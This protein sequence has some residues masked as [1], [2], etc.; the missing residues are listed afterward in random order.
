MLSL[1]LSLAASRRWILFG[2]D[3]TAAF[4]QGEEI[5]RTLVLSLPKDG[6]DG[7]E[8]G[9]LLL[10]RKP[11]YG[12]RDAPRG[13]WKR[14]HNAVLQHGLRP[15]PNEPAAYV[16]RSPQGQVQG[17]VVCHVDDLLW[18][19]S[20]EMQDVMG[21]LQQELRFGALEQG[22]FSYC[23]RVLT[24]TP[25]GIRVT[26]PNTAAKVRPVHLAQQR[27][28]QKDHPATDQEIN[29]LR[30]VLGSLNWV[31]RVCRPDISYELSVLQSVQKKA[32]VQDLLD[33]N[34]LLR[35]V[36]E[37]P[38]VGLFFPYEALDFDKATILSITDAS[39]AANFDTGKDGE[40]LGNRSQS[41]RIL[42]LVSPDF[43]DSG[44][45][46]AYPLEYHSNVIRR[47]CRSTLQAETL[48]MVQGYEEA[49]HL[50][51]VLF[52]LRN[53]LVGDWQV[54]ALDS[55]VVHLLTDCR[56]LEA[57]L[58]QPGLGTTSDKRLAI[59]MS[60]LRQMI[61]RCPG[62]LHGDPLYGDSVPSSGTTKAEWIETKSMVSDALTK[63]MKSVQL[64]EFMDTGVLIFDMDR[65]SKRKP[66]PV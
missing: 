47:V 12:T 43:M 34:R 33:C 63:K 19:G 45:G 24:Q 38:E 61:W 27:R 42:C 52:A 53:D 18:C 31:A 11:V 2:G 54:K 51:T 41:G 15:V 9:S 14:L 13:F 25:E 37:S 48:S 65:T 16:L 35:Y 40:P 8:P 28:A 49:E 17:L 32:V 1:T 44:K 23:G 10:A 59:D 58:K 64:L 6:V 36:Q 57:H 4:L 22:S 5:T 62:E 21:K 3:I 46:K 55:T 60:A 26:C 66:N 20:Q 7:V 50:R 56:S 30:S 29:Q 39:Y